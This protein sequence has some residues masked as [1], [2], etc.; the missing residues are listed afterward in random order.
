MNT[1]KGY[2]TKIYDVHLKVGKETRDKLDHVQEEY[3]LTQSK[4]IRWAVLN[5]DFSDYSSGGKTDADD[6]SGIKADQTVSPPLNPDMLVTWQVT[7]EVLSKI[8]SEFHRVGGNLNQVAKNMNIARSQGN[9]HFTLQDEISVR[10]LREDVRGKY[11]DISA[12]IGY[13]EV[14]CNKQ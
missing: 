2:G 10:E 7:V 9:S 5:A 8:Q 12:L 13:L 6:A 1:R 11:E 14:L 3:G 4:A